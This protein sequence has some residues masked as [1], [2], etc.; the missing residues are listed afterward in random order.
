MRASVK[1]RTL[2]CVP[3]RCFGV[4]AK[5]GMKVR[6]RLLLWAYMCSTR[7]AILKQ[8]IERLRECRGRDL[9]GN[10]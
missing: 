4:K 3:G 7:E 2:F 1:Q 5:S 10:K 8:W 9:E 6:F